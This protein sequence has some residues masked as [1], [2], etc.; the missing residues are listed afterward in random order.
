MGKKF[1]LTPER[2]EEVFKAQLEHTA[3]LI[4]HQLTDHWHPT[5]DCGDYLHAALDLSARLSFA[6]ADGLNALVDEFFELATL[7]NNN[8]D[9]GSTYLYNNYACDGIDEEVIGLITN[10]SGIKF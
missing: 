7:E 2:A 8:F 10:I 1:I 3:T 6:R 5:D 9:G 4:N